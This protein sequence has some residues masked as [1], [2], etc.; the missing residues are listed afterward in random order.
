MILLV[1]G[2]SFGLAGFGKLCLEPSE[3]TQFFP[4]FLVSKPEKTSDKKINLSYLN[5]LFFF[6]ANNNRL[7]HLSF[8][9]IHQQCCIATSGRCV[10]AQVA[11]MKN[12]RAVRTVHDKWDNRPIAPRQRA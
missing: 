7:I 11:F 4:D 6:D 1:N 9:L 3:R 2:L 12:M 5:H 8:G 10:N